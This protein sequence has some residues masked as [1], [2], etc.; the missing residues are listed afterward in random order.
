MIEVSSIRLVHFNNNVQI[1]LNLIQ[2]CDKICFF[3]TIKAAFRPN[4]EKWGPRDPN[5]RSE[6]KEFI[7]Y[8][9]FQNRGGLVKTFL[10]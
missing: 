8:K 5:I 10:K 1:L 7:A 6:W 4:E 3:Q 9:N 2:D